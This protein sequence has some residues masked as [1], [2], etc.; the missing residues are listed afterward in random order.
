MTQ[1][2]VE[3][4]VAKEMEVLKMTWSELEKKLKI[5]GVAASMN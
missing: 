1:E 3:E 4:K 2:H 5:C